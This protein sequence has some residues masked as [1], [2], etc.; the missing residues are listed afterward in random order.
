M[1]HF[2]AMRA[3]ATPWTSPLSYLQINALV[4]HLLCRNKRW[5]YL[6]WGW[7]YVNELLLTRTIPHFDDFFLISDFDS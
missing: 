3:A 2:A 1:P 7:V 4:V 6:E 5:A